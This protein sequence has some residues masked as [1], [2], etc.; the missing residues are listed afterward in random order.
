MLIVIIIIVEKIII[1]QTISL[2][3]YS[4][5]E[6]YTDSDLSPSYLHVFEWID[7]PLMQIVHTDIPLKK[8]IWK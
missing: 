8:K 6:E 2:L 1:S 5:F 7:V 4:V 3:C